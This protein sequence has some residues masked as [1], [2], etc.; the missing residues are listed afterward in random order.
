VRAGPA[1]RLT[2][3]VA[4]GVARRTDGS[5]GDDLVG[6]AR[7]ELVGRFLLDPSGQRRRG[8][9]AGGGLGVRRDGAGPWRD[10]LL[11]VVGIEGRARRG[12]VTAADLGVGGGVR[13][14][15]ALRRAADSGR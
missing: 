11:L 8:V 5:P 9:Y 3:L 12:L 13:V 1:V 2:A 6:S 7:A 14:G 4:A 10:L 15:V